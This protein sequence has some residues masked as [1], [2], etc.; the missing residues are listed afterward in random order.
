MSGVDDTEGHLQGKDVMT[1]QSMVVILDDTCRDRQ[2]NKPPLENGVQTHPR[3][4]DKFEGILSKH[5]I[6]MLL[7]MFD[8]GISSIWLLG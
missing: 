1:Q 5:D 7:T 8:T 3:I 4:E 6:D 2:F